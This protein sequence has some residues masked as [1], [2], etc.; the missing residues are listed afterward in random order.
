ME[1]AAEVDYLGPTSL[2]V[3]EGSCSYTKGHSQLMH[4]RII[5]Y[6]LGDLNN[7]NEKEKVRSVSGIPKQTLY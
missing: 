6:F 5:Y 7:H 4:M 3:R 1:N 2:M